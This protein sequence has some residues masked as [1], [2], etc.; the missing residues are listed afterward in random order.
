VNAKHAAAHP[1]SRTN[2]TGSLDAEHLGN[3]VACIRER[4][5][6]THSPASEAHAST[7]LTHLANI[8]QRT[9]ETVRLDPVTGRLAK[10]SA[11][12]ELWT[13]EYEKGWE[14]KV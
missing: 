11:G 6:D 7:L 1:A 4:R 5:T 9:G 2:P 8:A 13:R 10:G 12:N 3:W 14:M